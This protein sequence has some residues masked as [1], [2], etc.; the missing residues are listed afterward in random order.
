MAQLEHLSKD[1]DIS[2]SIFGKL[3]QQ[4]ATLQQQLANKEETLEHYQICQE[5]LEQIA[6]ELKGAEDK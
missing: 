4:L 3:D 1:I 6:S 5:R 2:K